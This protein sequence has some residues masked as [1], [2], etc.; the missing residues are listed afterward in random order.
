MSP[1]ASSRAPLPTLEAA[2]VVAVAAMTSR[3]G[4]RPPPA[5]TCVHLAEA[6]EVVETQSRLRILVCIP[7]TH[8]YGEH[9]RA[10]S[11]C[12]RPSVI[13]LQHTYLL[14]R[15]GVAVPLSADS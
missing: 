15:Q 12:P 8:K 14:L 13:A 10:S 2:T 6:E 11:A 9:I 4:R 5:R 1:H 7:G 3:S